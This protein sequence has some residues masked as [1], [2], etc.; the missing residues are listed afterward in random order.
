MVHCNSA[1]NGGKSNLIGSEVDLI[2]LL[3]FVT[4]A[5]TKETA[6]FNTALSNIH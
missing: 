2:D 4:N 1:K 3:V 6:V 5:K